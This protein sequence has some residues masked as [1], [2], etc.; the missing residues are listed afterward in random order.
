MTAIF[1]EK[2][3][4]EYNLNQLSLTVI[5]STLKFYAVEQAQKIV[6]LDIVLEHGDFI[7]N[8]IIEISERL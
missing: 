4:D 1:E 6:D 3:F 2:G 5:N 8:I 7:R